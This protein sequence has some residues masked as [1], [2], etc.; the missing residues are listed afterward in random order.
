MVRDTGGMEEP[1][2]RRT[3][4]E[5]VYIAMASTDLEETR[6]TATSRGPS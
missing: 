4:G 3:I 2:H 1:G 5:S 6:I